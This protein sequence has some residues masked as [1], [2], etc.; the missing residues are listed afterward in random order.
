MTWL[1]ALTEHLH[2]WIC[3]TCYYTVCSFTLLQVDLTSDVDNEADDHATDVA[4]QHPHH[5]NPQIGD[6][7]EW[8]QNISEK[9][10]VMHLWKFIRYNS[11]MDGNY[12]VKAD[13]FASVC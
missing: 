3:Q 2:V 10:I 11:I 9:W 4:D 12:D 8:L 1:N 5:S 7:V 6:V 13:D